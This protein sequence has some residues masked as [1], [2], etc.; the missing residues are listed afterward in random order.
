MGKLQRVSLPCLYVILINYT[1]LCGLQGLAHLKETLPDSLQAHLCMF[2]E[3]RSLKQKCLPQQGGVTVAR[4]DITCICIHYAI[5]IMVPAVLMT[6][7]VAEF[8][9]VNVVLKGTAELIYSCQ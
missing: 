3:F 1:D 9:A 2:S 4:I 5:M 7:S 8:T 6:S